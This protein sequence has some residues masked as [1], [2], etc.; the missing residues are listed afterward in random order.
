MRN[1]KNYNVWNHSIEL[2]SNVYHVVKALPQNE[3]FGLSQQIRRAAVSIPS[4][5]AEGCGRESEKE[6][7]RFLEVSL[8]SAFELETQLI[9]ADNLF[10]LKNENVFDEAYSRLLQ[11]QKELSALRSKLK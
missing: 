5:I 10:G 7:K 6:F 4:N 11:V 1:F 9:I 8:S 2:V 3:V